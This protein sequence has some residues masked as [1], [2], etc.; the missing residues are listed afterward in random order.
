MVW[1]IGW[2]RE[3]GFGLE[4]KG[5]GGRGESE[6]RGKEVELWGDVEEGWR[7]LLWRWG[8]SVRI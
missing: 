3:L 6:G 7:R 2:E 8:E 4:G 5:W 1:R